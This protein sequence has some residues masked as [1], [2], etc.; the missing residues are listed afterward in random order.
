[1]ISPLL[2]PCQSI[3]NKFGND[4]PKILYNLATQLKEYYK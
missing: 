1:M 2:A 3:W 4:N